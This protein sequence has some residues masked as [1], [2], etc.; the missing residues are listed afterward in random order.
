MHV[1]MYTGTLVLI[2]LFHLCTPHRKIFF[3]ENNL[4]DN[5]ASHHLRPLPLPLDHVNLNKIS[6]LIVLLQQLRC[7]HT[8][9]TPSRFW[10]HNRAT[11]GEMVHL[12]AGWVYYQVRR[13]DTLKC[14]NGWCS[15]SLSLEARRSN[16][17]GRPMEALQIV[18]P[19]L[20]LINLV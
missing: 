5:H 19:R 11:S 16:F 4:K 12:C 7:K 15:R 13:L 14:I 17:K 2:C 3:S 8:L 20:R 10:L 1:C 9:I 18:D 6:R